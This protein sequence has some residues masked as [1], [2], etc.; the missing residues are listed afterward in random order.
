MIFLSLKELKAIAMSKNIKDYVNKSAK[1]LL[2]L[3][4][5]SNIKIGISRNILKEIEK[6]FKELRQNFSK[7]EINKFRKIFY[8]IKNHGNIYI[9]KIK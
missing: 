9:S 8:D 3:F 5:D 4:N 6:K 2:K 1:D 7:K